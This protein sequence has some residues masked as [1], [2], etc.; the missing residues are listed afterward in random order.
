[1]LEMVQTHLGFMMQ[2]L[3]TKVMPTLWLNESCL[4][5]PHG[6]LDLDI[7]ASNQF[8]ETLKSVV[9]DSGFGVEMEMKIEIVFKN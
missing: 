4:F 5:F 6:R 1:M 9:L 8:L 7:A 3:Y 2:Q